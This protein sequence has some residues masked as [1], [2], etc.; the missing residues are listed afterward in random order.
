MAKKE[1]LI[2]IR[3]LNQEEIDGLL[4]DAVYRRFGPVRCSSCEKKNGFTRRIF[5]VTGVRKEKYSDDTTQGL[6][7]YHFLSQF[8]IKYIF[9]RENKKMLYI[10]SSSCQACKSTAIVYD[11]LLDDPTVAEWMNKLFPENWTSGF[12]SK[13]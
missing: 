4:S 11:I 6:L 1:Q 13:K 9:F 10:D 3:E 12:N 8:K 5:H 7:E 2:S